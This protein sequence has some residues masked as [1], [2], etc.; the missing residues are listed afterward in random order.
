MAGLICATIV[1]AEVVVSPEGQ[2][3]HWLQ[4]LSFNG[5]R[6]QRLA[7]KTSCGFLSLSA[8]APKSLRSFE[9]VGRVA[10]SLRAEQGVTSLQKA[11]QAHVPTA[12]KVV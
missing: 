7:E 4:R 9:D 5:F 3:L 11:A 8:M 1:Q 2:L 10:S 12:A 6:K